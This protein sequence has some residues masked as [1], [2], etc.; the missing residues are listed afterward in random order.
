M[1]GKH[2]ITCHDYCSGPLNLPESNFQQE[3]HPSDS[4][5]FMFKRF[6]LCHSS[7]YPLERPIVWFLKIDEVVDLREDIV[8]NYVHE[9]AAGCNVNKGRYRE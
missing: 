4:S 9:I 8:D 1:H 3:G 6:C 7:R 2:A 5:E